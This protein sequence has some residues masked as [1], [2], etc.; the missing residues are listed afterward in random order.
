MDIL[1]LKFIKFVFMPKQ[2]QDYLNFSLPKHYLNQRLK[3]Q[4][5]DLSF[6]ALIGFRIRMGLQLAQLKL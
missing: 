1:V 2:I 5:I 3:F 6:H 4:I